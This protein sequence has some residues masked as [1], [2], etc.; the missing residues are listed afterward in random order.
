MLMPIYAYLTTPRCGIEIINIPTTIERSKASRR[1]MDK[2][3]NT[4]PSVGEWI[5]LSFFLNTD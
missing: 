3:V 1:D 2:C 4:S 5:E